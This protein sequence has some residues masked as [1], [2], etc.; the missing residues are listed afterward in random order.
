MKFNKHYAL[1]GIL[2]VSYA[3]LT[4]IIPPRASVLAKY[5]ISPTQAR[6]LSI[7]IIVPY[8]VI[9]FAAF[10][11]YVHC[12][13]YARFIQKSRDGKAMAVL[14]DGLMYLAIGLPVT[15]II[16]TV[17]KYIAERNPQLMPTT[18]IITNYVAVILVF[19][20]FG[21]I[22][23]G[24]RLF[25]Q[26]VKRPK[27]SRLH[28]LMITSFGIFCI[29]YIFVTLVN[30][31]RQFPTVDSQRA[32]YYLPDFLLITTIVIPYI[33]VW[34][35]GFFATYRIHAYKYHVKGV[36]YKEALVRL[37]WGIGWVVLSS[38]M[39]RLLV[40]LTTLLNTLALNILL[41]VIYVLLLCILAGYLFIA[42]G[43]KKLKKIEEV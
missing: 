5:N 23:K 35:L 13:Q 19:I 22:S 36:I 2:S 11:G 24:T 41:V 38:M 21:T 28:I 18:T 15:A 7:T 39:L 27:R 26:T 43:A 1:W 3:F 31:A 8:V 9:W 20:A 10:Y 37:A 40:S 29:F 33:I 12:K 16:T 42:S 17:M 34:Y 25:M 4:L 14:A 6:L 32:A 30:P